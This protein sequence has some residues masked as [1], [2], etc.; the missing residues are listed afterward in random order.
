MADDPQQKTDLLWP[1]VA[2][3]ALSR[4]AFGAAMAWRGVPA[5]AG[6]DLPFA[7]ANDVVL[8]LA[9]LRLRA[10]GDRAARATPTLVVAPFA[11]HDATIA[12]FAPGH[13]LVAA[14]RA[15]GTACVHLVEWR[16]ATAE[17]RYF[18]IDSY[19]AELNVV[20]DELGGR[21]NLAGLCQGGWLSLVYA[22]RFPAKI[23]RLALA[24]APVDLEAAE[25]SLTLSVRNAP[26]GVYESLVSMGGGRA[27]GGA[28]LRFWSGAAQLD[29]MGHEALQL[30]APDAA[31]AARFRDW[32]DRT[33]DLPGAYYL[34]AVDW[35]F[36]RNRL[37]KG[38]FPA[39]G[40]TVDLAC[41]DMP[42]YIL[43]GDADQTCVLPQV[44]ATRD[45][46]GS[47]DVTIDVA[48]SDHL[49][50]FMGRHSVAER[51][52]RIGAWLAGKPVR[53][54]KPPAKKPRTMS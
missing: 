52:P 50:L 43:A 29:A 8:E 42:V 33:I 51:W 46:V 31:L 1:W 25:S 13:S 54:R 5:A 24:G 3:S 16:S 41:V 40:R 17:M 30:D 45:L 32:Y 14:L 6:C 38:D 26:R 9:G 36:R 27:M 11:L 37:A 15:G 48:P 53:R 7:S 22:A 4:A 39:L 21:V 20:V 10:F 47:A 12:D 34:Q 23:A 44:L 18:D 19:L 2:V 28:M 35:L 49:G